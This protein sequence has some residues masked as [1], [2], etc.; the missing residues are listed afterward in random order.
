MAEEKLKETLIY[1]VRHGQTEWNVEKRIQGQL[2]SKLTEKGVQEAI[3]VG[4]RFQAEK[5]N[6]DVIYSSDLGRVRQTRDLICRSLPNIPI[7]E[8]ASL[9]EFNFGKHQGQLSVDIREQVYKIH[10]DMLSNDHGGESRQAFSDRVWNAFESLAISNAG[11]SVLVVTH[12]GVVKEFILRVFGI[13]PLKKLIEVSNS[14]ISV[15]KYHIPMK[16]FIFHSLC[17]TAHLTIPFVKETEDI[18]SGEA[19]ES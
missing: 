6:F 17:D 13:S 7:F 2:D 16:Q 12:G 1:I 11:K 18:Q 10:K 8:D 19:S 14:S 9:R 3:L 4:K 15:C 5:A